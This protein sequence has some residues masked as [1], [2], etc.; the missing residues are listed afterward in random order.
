MEEI[1]KADFRAVLSDVPWCWTS[2]NVA[3]LL[4]KEFPY[5]LGYK[6]KDPFEIILFLLSLIND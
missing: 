5:L 3:E 1:E 2:Q 4:F 6:R